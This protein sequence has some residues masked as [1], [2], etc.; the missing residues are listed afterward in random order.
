M[1]DG[2]D[3]LPPGWREQLARDLAELLA[4]AEELADGGAMGETPEDFAE[5]LKRRAAAP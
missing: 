5:A 1:D 3:A 2:K 4:A